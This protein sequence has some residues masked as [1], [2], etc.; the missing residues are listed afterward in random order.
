M[1]FGSEGI[2]DKLTGLALSGGGFRAT[3][4]HLGALWR[5]NELAY[6][7]KIDRI[8]TVSGGSITAGVL[9]VQWGG[10]QW[11]N[12]IATNFQAAIADRLRAFCARPLDVG[13]IAEGAIL[14]WKEISEA[15]EEAYRSELFGNATLQ[16][17]PQRPRFIFN[18]TNF[19][20]G[21]D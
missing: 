19:M 8:S 21:R 11:A 12:G 20:T 15:I 6:L 17:L 10:L 16:D 2:D 13:A 3:L 7:P 4:F 18:S 9:A 14:P 1:P 5:L